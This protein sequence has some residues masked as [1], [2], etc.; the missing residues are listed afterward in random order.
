MKTMVKVIDERLKK[1]MLFAEMVFGNGN[2]PDFEGELLFMNPT[3]DEFASADPNFKEAVRQGVPEH[4]VD[5][6]LI[7]YDKGAKRA[8]FMTPSKVEVTSVEG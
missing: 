5:A 2:T 4:V 6:G 3:L 8:F 7:Y 1:E